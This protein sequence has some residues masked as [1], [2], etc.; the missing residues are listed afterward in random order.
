MGV[1]IR[2]HAKAGGTYYISKDQAVVGNQVIVHSMAGP[3]SDDPTRTL[4]ASLDATSTTIALNTSLSE[5]TLVRIDNE[6][7]KLGAWNGNAHINCERGYGGGIPQP[8]ASGTTV[9]ALQT[10]WE[11]TDAVFTE[12]R[13]VITYC[14]FREDA[15]G[16]SIPSEAKAIALPTPPS[17]RYICAWGIVVY[18]NGKPASGTT[19]TLEL[20]DTNDYLSTGEYLLAQKLETQTGADGFFYFFLPRSALW[21]SEDGVQKLVLTI[22]PGSAIAFT[23]QI[24]VVPSHVE[25][26]FLRL[27]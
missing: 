6:T 24:T 20:G 4:T 18:A 21:L 16:L 2:W 12:N 13:H 27:Q 26:N 14:V 17:D 19:I 11:D 10:S 23:R 3:T 7:I 8:H 15:N 22:A 5:N 25:R 1:I 9:Y